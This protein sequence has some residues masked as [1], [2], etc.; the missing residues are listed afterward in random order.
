MKKSKICFLILNYITYDETVKCVESIFN[1]IDTKNFDIVIVD[2]CSPDKSGEKL[3]NRYINNS[4]IHVLLNK[5]N[6]GFLAGNNV[7]YIYARNKLNSE[8]IVMLNS[9]TFLI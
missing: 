6:I 2:N 1:N 7:G 8:F 3:V 4:N 5:D 9:D